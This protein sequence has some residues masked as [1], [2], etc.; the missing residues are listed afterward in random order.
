[1]YLMSGSTAV[2]LCDPQSFQL[3]AFSIALSYC[4]QH[5]TGTME[6]AFAS[7]E[8]MLKDTVQAVKMA[9]AMWSIDCCERRCQHVRLMRA[10]DD[11]R[12]SNDP[13]CL[14]C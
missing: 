4:R 12:N 11:Q 2:A 1:M 14:T 9:R 6:V 8:H 10:A 7:A 13:G 5:V 3:T